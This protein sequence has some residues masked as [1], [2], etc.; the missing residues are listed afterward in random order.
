MC[1]LGSFHK[2]HEFFAAPAEYLRAGVMPENPNSS[3]CCQ[4]PRKRE[5]HPQRVWELS[6]K[7]LNVKRIEVK[8]RPQEVSRE[9]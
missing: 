4:S 3:H 1:A 5:A 8:W 7:C 2:Q 6:R 9:S